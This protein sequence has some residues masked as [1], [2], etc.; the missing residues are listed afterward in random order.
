MDPDAEK[1]DYLLTVYFDFTLFRG[2][3]LKDKD[4][5]LDVNIGAFADLL[6]F[7]KTILSEGTNFTSPRVPNITRGVDWV[8]LHCDLVSREVT[9]RDETWR[10]T[11]CTACRPSASGSAT[12]SK[13]LHNASS[14]TPSAKA[15]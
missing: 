1:K 3:V 11:F 10:T 6:G 4:H 9:R 15:G 13:K 8:F 2:V 7:D 14:T 5:K 12:L